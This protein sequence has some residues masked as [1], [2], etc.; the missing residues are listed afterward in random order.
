M[1]NTTS[2]KQHDQ[3]F[4]CPADFYVSLVSP[5]T[6]REWDK[7]TDVG[8]EYFDNYELEEQLQDPN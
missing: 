8:I 2:A 3:T 7:E 4:E 6:L 1:T 5:E